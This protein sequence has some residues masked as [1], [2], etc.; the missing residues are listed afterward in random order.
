MSVQDI[1]DVYSEYQ[2]WQ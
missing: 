2:Q 1:S